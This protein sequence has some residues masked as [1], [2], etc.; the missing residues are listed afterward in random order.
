M[1]NFL[2]I[3]V[4]VLITLGLCSCSKCSRQVEPTD[5][6]TV[7][8]VDELNVENIISMDR[9][10]MFLNYANEDTTNY[11]WF[12]TCIVLSDFIDEE[13]DY[14][15]ESIANVFQILNNKEDGMDTHVILFAHNTTT[16]A[17]DVKHGFWVGDFEINNEEIT[18]TFEQALEKVMESN[19]VKPHSK[20]VVLRKEV[21][22]KPCNA[23]YI[24]GNV[25]SQLYVDAIT[26]DVTDV[27][28]A[29]A[30]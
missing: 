12:E 20:Q 28:P 29:F 30:E 18:I 10:D 23:Q 7:I 6:E 5:E 21:G 15:V 26:G 16:S 14:K 8:T 22:P 11:S 19:F 25:K 3:I 2:M 17:V 4:S 27:N 24:F 9:E 1:K 13:G